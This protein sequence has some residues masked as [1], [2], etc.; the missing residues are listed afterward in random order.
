MRADSRGG[1]F[2]HLLDARTPKG[3]AP[4]FADPCLTLKVAGARRHYCPAAE[5]PQAVLWPLWGSLVGFQCRR[6]AGLAVT[7]REGFVH[8]R[9]HV[10]RGQRAM[11]PL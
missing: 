2:I 5:V 11:T 3:Q 4:P 1:L 10:G 8:R 9:V 6:L 7:P